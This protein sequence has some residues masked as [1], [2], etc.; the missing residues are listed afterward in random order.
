MSEARKNIRQKVVE[1]LLYKTAAEDRVFS[2]PARN[3]WQE[4][5]PAI[6]VYSRSETVNEFSSAPRT[7]KRS[8]RLAIECVANADENLDDQLDDLTEEVERA[9]G[10]DES[11][12]GLASD[13]LLEEVTMELKGDGQ[14]VIGSC[15][16]TYLVTYFSEIKDESEIVP[17]EGIDIAYDLNSNESREAE[18]KIDLP[19]E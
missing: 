19:Q 4:N 1:L 8:L 12:G 3:L 17:L 2:N 18:D 15:A 16:L 13:C 5:L 10:A 9:L 7:L 6:L 14:T 11:L